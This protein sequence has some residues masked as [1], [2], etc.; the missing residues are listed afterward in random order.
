MMTVLY[1]VGGVWMAL[2]LVF[3]LSLGLAA[4]KPLTHP[5]PA[6]CLLEEAA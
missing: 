2:S 3:V 4:R 6:A 5:E 1:I